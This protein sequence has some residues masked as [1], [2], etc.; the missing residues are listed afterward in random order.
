MQ[1]IRGFAMD[2]H[3][4]SI[5]Q[6]A[7][8]VK[9]T[10]IVT[11]AEKSG[12]GSTYEGGWKQRTGW[13]WQSPFGL[14]ANDKEPAV[15]ITFKEAKAFC[16]W[17][18][19]RLPTD[20]EWMEAAYTEHRTTP[21]P[22]FTNGQT[23]PYPT[24]AKPIGANCLGDCGGAPTLSKYAEPSITTRGRGHVLTASTRA[25]VNG[26]W[27]MGGNVWEWTDNGSADAGNT[28]QPTR[29]GS[30]WYGAEQMHRS[31]LQTKP[32]DTAVVYIGFRCAK[33]SG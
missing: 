29:G 20:A 32:A 3:E 11:E 5:A 17:A 4:V 19:K 13:T 10:G 30:W 2:V 7:R 22:E 15:H 28:H 27:D 33:S 25:G 24:G 9:A 16:Q 1:R 21:P 8:Y 23:Y 14:A 12:G 26:L 18:G 6:F 31:H